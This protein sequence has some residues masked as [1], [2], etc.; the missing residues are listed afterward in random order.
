M[1]KQYLEKESQVALEN[2]RDGSITFITKEMQTLKLLYS[3]SLVRLAKMKNLQ[4]TQWRCGNS[5]SHKHKRLLSLS[6]AIWKYL[7]YT[8]F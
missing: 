6:T 3:S 5:H 4:C 1:N 2:I 7:K 8:H